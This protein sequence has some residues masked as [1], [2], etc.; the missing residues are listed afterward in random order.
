MTDHDIGGT[1]PRRGFLRRLAAAAAMVGGSVAL[2]AP[3]AAASVS[4]VAD[5]DWMKALTG[6]HRTVFDLGAHRNG[7][8]LMQS[9]N[10][11]DAWRDSFKVPEDQVNLVVGVQGEGIPIVLSDALWSRFHIG[12]HFELTDPATKAPATRNPFIA[13]NVAT[14]GLVNAEQ[15]VEALQKR[16]V[17]FVACRNAIGAIAAR[18][19]ALGL[20]PVDEVRAALLAD[21]LPGVITVP[22][23]VVALAQLQERGLT[24]VKI[25]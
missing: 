9:K 8:P 25:S 24:Y 10:Y 20:G 13:A 21:L 7:R 2:P 22:A 18:L 6:K 12:Q 11:L 4:D 19:S 23:M 14:A 5:D 17:R 3:L 15:S 16:G 1:T